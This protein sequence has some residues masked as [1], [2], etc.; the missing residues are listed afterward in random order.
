MKNVKKIEKDSYLSM[1]IGI[2]ILFVFAFII[3][4][5]KQQKNENILADMVDNEFYL[6]TIP[7]KQIVVRDLD[8][9]YP[10]YY[11]FYIDNTDNTYIAHSFNYYQTDSQYELEFSIHRKYIVDYNYSDYMIRY[12]CDSGKGDYE[13][14]MERLPFIIDTFNYKIY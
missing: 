5:D 7:S 13:D 3:L 14:I 2:I 6:R 11:V 9:I 10:R 4:I 8:V 1:K 12:I